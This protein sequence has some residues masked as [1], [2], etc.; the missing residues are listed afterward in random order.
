MKK[1]LRRVLVDLV[2]IVSVILIIFSV[3]V[4][5]KVIT[6]KQGEVP[7]IFG[8]SLFRVVTGSMEPQIPVDSLIIVKKTPAEELQVGDVISFYSRDP[9]LR[10]EVNTH[11]I[12]EIRLE[13]RGYVFSTKGDA[14][15]V[16]DRYDTLEEDLL[17]KVV[18]SSNLFGRFVRLL[19]N[20]LIFF[21][22]IILPLA[23]LILKNLVDSFKTASQLAREEEEAAVREAL[24]EIKEKRE[25]QQQ[26][27]HQTEQELTEQEHIEQD[28]KEEPKKE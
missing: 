11:R 6:T 22:F 12:V 3:F 27:L 8:Y 4:L 21:P 17:G 23:L 7:N 20:P 16:L 5:F 15:N 25:A 9:S 26:A 19:S 10:G 14:N 24:Q 2:S 13:D 28:K 18:F 1:K